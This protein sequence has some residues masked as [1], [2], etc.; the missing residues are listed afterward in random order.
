MF[1]S[2]GS[3]NSSGEAPFWRDQEDIVISGISGRFPRCDNVQEF[4]DLLLE[5]EDL[6][7]EDDLRWP[8]GEFHS[9]WIFSSSRFFLYYL[10]FCTGNLVE[11]N[12]KID[13]FNY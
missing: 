13:D 9:M 4:G 10:C 11:K 6:V 7:T 12:Q 8:P 1:Q 2:N 5:G 3:M